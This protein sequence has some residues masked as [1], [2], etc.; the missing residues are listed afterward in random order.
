MSYNQN[1]TSNISK[2]L[3]TFCMLSGEYAK[4]SSAAE[5]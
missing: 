2:A 1:P 4:A 3:S 5:I